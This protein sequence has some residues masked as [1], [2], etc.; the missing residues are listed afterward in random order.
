MAEMILVLKSREMNASGNTGRRRETSCRLWAGGRGKREK[1]VRRCC[2]I[3]TPGDVQ[4]PGCVSTQLV[5]EVLSLL[6]VQACRTRGEQGEGV[7][8][9]NFGG[10]RRTAAHRRERR[11]G[12]DLYSP[13]S[14]GQGHLRTE[15]SRLLLNRNLILV[16]LRHIKEVVSP[17]FL[18][19]KTVAFG[20]F[21]HSV[22]GQFTHDLY[23]AFTRF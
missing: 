8:D 7:M 3:Q 21:A 20:Y 5:P 15:F 4:R 6:T 19:R 9:A 2:W 10:T 18:V 1:R 17:V 12:G 22:S 16:S 11:I 13:H 23:L 14:D